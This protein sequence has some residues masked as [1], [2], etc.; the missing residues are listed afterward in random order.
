MVFSTAVFEPATYLAEPSEPGAASGRG[1][2]ERAQVIAALDQAL[3]RSPYLLGDRF[4]A[5]QATSPPAST[6]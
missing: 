5:A 6:S 3:T 2:G 4:T 1:W